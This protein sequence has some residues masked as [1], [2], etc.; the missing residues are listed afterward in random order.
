MNNFL[1][2]VKDNWRAATADKVFLQCLIIGLLVSSIIVVAQ[3]AFYRH[4]EA[5]NGVVLHDF[6]LNKITPYN[7]S[8]PIFIIIWGMIFLGIVRSLITPRIF[9]HYMMG[10][11]VITFLRIICLST[12]ALDPPIGIVELKDPFTDLFYGG[13]FI[14]KDLFFSGHTATLIL[15]TLALE[16]KRD[17]VL[18]ITAATIVGCLLLV[19]HVH[20]TI[21]VIAAPVFAWVG[22]ISGQKILAFFRLKYLQSALSTQEE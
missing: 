2:K 19:Q 7:V 6:L 15:L 12:I 1:R 17:K 20:Y 5:R 3:P 22:Y 10:F 18:C 14:T 21:D 4:I 13:V 16:K 8:V 11:I 9:L